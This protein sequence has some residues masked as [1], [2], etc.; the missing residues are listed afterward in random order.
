MPRHSPESR[1]KDLLAAATRV[2]IA[3]GYRR[4]QMADVAREMGVAKGTPYLYV[5]SKEA[6]FEAVLLASAERLPE[7]GELDLPLSARPIEALVATL[8]QA[9]EEE[10]TPTGL[11]RALAKPR[12]A[13]PRAELESIVRE[14][15]RAAN[16][17]RTSIKLIDRCARDQPELAEAFY[18][19]GRLAQLA[20]L[21]RFLR[22]RIEAGQ[23]QAV[24]DAEIA[25]RFIIETVATW[26]VHIHWDPAPQPIDPAI[27]EDTAVHFVLSGLTKE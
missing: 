27:A 8:Q 26:A 4:A 24:P 7:A 12:A 21:T 25:A 14:L 5:E 23:L 3:E 22:M 18:R 6:L 10:A 11:L 20:L 9:L 13:D 16:R 19:G 15:Y 1:F 17:H 2:F